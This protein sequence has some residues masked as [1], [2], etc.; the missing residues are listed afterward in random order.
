MGPLISKNQY[1]HVLKLITTGI[2][3][4]QAR[5]V[6]GGNEATPIG[7]GGQQ[8]KDDYFVQP[9]FFSHV[10]NDMTIAQTEIFGPVLCIL[11]YQ[12]VEEGIQITNDTVW[13][14]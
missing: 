8:C 9:T 6:Y 12:T 3:D 5:L 11:K 10:T 2:E 7:L 4:D 1:Q 13:L 14:E